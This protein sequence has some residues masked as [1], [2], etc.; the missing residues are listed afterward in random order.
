MT[1]PSLNSITCEVGQCE[2]GIAGCSLRCGNISITQCQD[3]PSTAAITAARRSLAR[4]HG[5]GI[6]KLATGRHQHVSGSLAAKLL[7][8]YLPALPLNLKPLG[9]QSVGQSFWTGLCSA[10]AWMPAALQAGSWVMEC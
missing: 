10:A 1:E 9:R 3:K 8:T 2:K 4:W 5:P 6:K 7:R